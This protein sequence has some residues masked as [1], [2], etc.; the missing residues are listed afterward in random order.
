MEKALML[1]ITDLNQYNEEKKEIVYDFKDAK[2]KEEKLENLNDVTT[3]IL[4][5]GNTVFFGK[6]V[7][8]NN[9]KVYINNV[10][11][12]DCK[13]DIFSLKS[14]SRNEFIN[15]ARH[16]PAKNL[17]TIDNLD[18]K[19]I[20]KD[21][22]ENNV[23]HFFIIK[24][25]EFEN[26]KSKL[27]EEDKIA[28]IDDNFNI[29]ELKNYNSKR[30]IDNM[31]DYSEFREIN[32]NKLLNAEKE[33]KYKEKKNED[34]AKNI[35][36]LT[37]I[38]E[39]VRTNGYYRFEN[40]LNF[41]DVL[42]NKE[43]KKRVQKLQNNNKEES[44]K[45]QEEK[46]IRNKNT[47]K[48]KTKET[49]QP[50]NQ[51]LYGPPGTGKTYNTIIKAMEIIDSTR[52]DDVDNETYKGLKN[53]F[54]ELKK[55]GQIEFITFHQ[56]FSYEE[57]IE[58]IKPDVENTEKIVYKIENGIFKKIVDDALF[59]MLNITEQQ[60]QKEKEF[61]EVLN[62]FKINHQE[63]TELNTI[64]SQS[65]FIIVEYLKDSI[66]IKPKDGSYIYSVS[67]EPLQEIYEKD[68][69]NNILTAKELVERMDGRFAGLSSYYFAVLDNLKKYTKQIETTNQRT[70]DFDK[71][72]FL[73]EYYSGNIK[74]KENPNK[75][76]LIIDEINRGNI[77]KIFGE[78]I[79][80]IEEDKRIGN[81]HELKLTLPYSKEPFG[82]PNNLYI[83]GTMNTSDRS[84]ASVDI[85]L[86][87]RFKFIEM[88]PKEDLVTDITIGKSKNF[89]D[90]FK[91]LNEKITILLD[92][93]HQIG[94]SYF[95]E[96]KFKTEDGKKLDNDI[97]IEMLKNIWFDE[98]LPLLNEYFYND[99]EKLQAL[100]GEA[101][102]N[103][104]S[105][106]VVKETKLPFYQYDI[107]D[108]VYDFIDKK[109]LNEENF[110]LALL[111]IIEEPKSKQKET[112]EQ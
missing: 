80:L 13:C 91:A 109:N 75:Y 8:F 62:I 27:E 77:S 43:L 94:H 88:M 10:D 39:E 65:K 105:F 97:K 73:K 22:E 24:K 74:L 25:S 48:P 3:V 79:T 86:R 40:F 18:I 36:E 1:P 32:L 63:G 5:K 15:F 31:E 111:K 93:D 20:K 102:K 90:I 61:D 55:F 41:Y 67:Y 66:R 68:K 70:I 71:S 23:Y 76:I 110:K 103:N 98:I 89:K 47:E 106:I 19:Q 57:F 28:F 59:N 14:T 85:A 11:V 82:I 38:I 69:E 95:I 49:K 58:G 78:L 26:L 92:R 107:E 45:E 35:K 34:K 51:I 54:D 33:R 4:R 30:E 50:L 37:K 12:F 44:K 101:S 104:D 42:I 83:I 72:K 52:Y 60:E 7:K 53:K 6:F 87:R 96:D 84:I 108:K 16:F 17:L 81:K 21:I 112:D 56:S 100:L 2:I 46:D 9:N 64:S 99:W 29:T